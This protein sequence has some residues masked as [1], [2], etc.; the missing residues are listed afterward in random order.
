MELEGRLVV[1][2]ESELVARGSFAGQPQDLRLWTEG[3]LLHGGP[4]DAPSFARSRPLA[5]DPALIIG[6]T[7]MGVLHNIAMLVGGAP[8][9]HADGGVEDWVQTVEHH[10][11]QRADASGI[12]FALR[13]DGQP[14]GEATVWLDDEGLPIE[15]EQVV[16]FPEGQMR[17]RETYSFIESVPSGP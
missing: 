11:V 14:S 10:H 12:A 1:G 6:F 9:D 5:L 13:V 15:R 17:V 8:P 4:V 3:D 16:D 7:R 2:E